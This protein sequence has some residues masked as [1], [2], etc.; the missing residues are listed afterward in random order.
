MAPTFN[1]LGADLSRIL[2]S[3][4]E[5]QYPLH[6][7]VLVSITTAL[8]GA[9]LLFIQNNPDS[10]AAKR[11]T[12]VV[13]ALHVLA[14]VT[15]AGQRISVQDILVAALVMT[16]FEAWRTITHSTIEGRD[17]DAPSTLA[18]KTLLSS[19]HS[20]V[21]ESD[22]AVCP[23][24]KANN[25]QGSVAA[26]TFATADPKD[27]EIMHLQNTLIEVKTAEKN[28][29]TDLKRTQVDLR[30]AR[31]TLTETFAEYTSL[32]DE[33]KTMK[34]NIGRDQQSVIY[35]KDIE[36]FALR[37]SIEQKESYIKEK[38]VKV[39][40][41]KRQ[42]KAT[43]ELKDAQI[44]SLKDRVAI[45][46]SHEK[47]A[48]HNRSKSE[49]QHQAAL[50]VKLLKVNGRSSEEIERPSEEKDAEIARLRDCLA[51][52][53]KASETLAHAQAEL[54][55]AWD[56]TLEAER[57]LNEERRHHAQ[58]RAEL[59]ETANRFE[60][61][62]KRSSQKSSPTRL[63]TID[64]QDR[65][66]LEAM[67]NAA[68]QDNLRLYSNLDAA[69]KELREITTRLS[70]AEQ[71][72]DALREQLKLEQSISADM[73]TAR[74]SIVHRVHFQR[75]EG[76]LKESR[77]LLTAKNDE[78]QQLQKSASAKDAEISAIKKTKEAAETTQFQLQAENENLKKSIT[79]LEATKTQLMMDHERL[80]KYRA[81]DR[82]SNSSSSADHMSARS[83]GATLITEPVHLV[84][85]SEV[86]LPDRPATVVGESGMVVSAADTPKTN[87]LVDSPRANGFSM[88]SND[89][90]PLELRSSRRKS[91]TLKGL[92]RKMGRKEHDEATEKEVERRDRPKTAL[93][94]G[95]KD[96]NAALRPKTALETKDKNAQMRPKTAID[97]LSKKGGDE[98]KT[99]VVLNDASRQEAVGPKTSTA[100]QKENAGAPDSR[101]PKS[102]GWGSQS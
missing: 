52:A 42:H 102:R 45:F 2:K 13:N 69:D 80:A 32:R 14:L 71:E 53:E 101:R 12:Q 89:T 99:A 92:M 70:T 62:L 68:Q 37:K 82:N 23:G 100:A 10:W 26:R 76:Q 58:T 84:M 79:E 73:E 1:D 28:K 66:E 57:A 24:N 56:A 33:M 34:A 91:L 43:L 81:R 18:V 97:V 55:R 22:I 50:R 94:L 54:R 9:F 49:G 16:S 61:E 96:K 75:M 29:E 3:R 93:A 39:D 74:P 78:I 38:D 77:D 7:F 60:D 30:N 72:L 6:R 86:P 8:P 5:T 59:Q 25:A 31:E 95:P 83:S 41:I 17:P 44:R 19:T 67:F 15:V 51:G 35:R 27:K 90:P 47:Q 65:K 64:E 48:I 46:E 21:A 11:R 36:L 40:E 63:P 20:T 4:W 85:Q 98:A 88:I 87:S